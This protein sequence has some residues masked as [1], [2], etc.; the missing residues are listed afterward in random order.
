MLSSAVAAL[1]VSASYWDNTP[2]NPL[3]LNPGESKDIQF[4]IQNFAGSG[5][6]VTMRASIET[7]ADLATISDRSNDYFVPFKESKAV[8][9]RVTAPANASI[10]DRFKIALLFTTVA[11][12]VKSGQ[13][14]FGSA[15]GQHFDLVITR[16]VIAEEKADYTWLLTLLIAA[17]II[18]VLAILYLQRKKKHK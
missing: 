3:V 18:V 1:G 15:I 4:V 16:E 12:D 11:K 8:N 17:I 5:G 6:D 14:S 2:P 7:G 9:M 10:G 13:F